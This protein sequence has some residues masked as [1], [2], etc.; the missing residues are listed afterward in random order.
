MKQN[1]LVLYFLL[2]F[3]ILTTGAL[4]QPSPVSAEKVYKEWQVFPD[5][6]NN[7]EIF[8]SIVKCNGVNQ[9]NLMIFNDGANDQEVRFSIEIAN[10]TDN[11]HFSVSRKFSAQKKVFHKATCE[12]DAPGELKI[13]L[14]DAF[15]PSGITVKQTL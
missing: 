2:L 10:N 15:D 1:P 7:V 4:A 14:P 3:S 8:Y 12:S 9:V 11:Q 6:K 5:S 13:V